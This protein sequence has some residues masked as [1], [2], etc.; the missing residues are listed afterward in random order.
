MTDPTTQEPL[1]PVPFGHALLPHFPFAPTFK[2]LNHGSFGSPPLPVLTTQSQYR[3]QLESRPDT[4]IRYT[5]GPLLDESRRAIAELV[6]APLDTVILLP[7]ATTGVNT[8]LR[9]LHYE[10]GDHIA[11]FST[12]YPACEKT[13]LYLCE[14]TAAEP[15]RVDLRYPLEDDEV[16]RKFRDALRG[17]EGRVK[18]AVLDTIV[19]LPG[20]R[21]PFEKLVQVCREEGVL[22]MIDG[23]HG[24]GHIDLD[25]GALDAD[26]FTSNCHKWLFTPRPCAILHVP[27]RNQPL[28]RSS[29]PTSHGYEPLPPTDPD[30][31]PSIANPFPPGST[32]AFAHLFSFVGTVD[33]TPYLSIPAALAFRRTVCGGEAAILSYCHGLAREGGRRAAA[34]L[35]TEVLENGTRTL[36]AGT[37]FANV[38]L[39]LSVGTGEAAD[40]G[41]RREDVAAVPAWLMRTMADES[42]VFVSVTRHAGHWWGRFSAQVYLEV[43][44]FEEGARVLK[45]LCERVG[46][47]E[48][49]RQTKGG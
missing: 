28:I 22:S 16:V 20:V 36:Q 24:L 26:F 30:S 4:F 44:D 41:V 3:T 40:G 10:R 2:N 23:A 15:V 37:C 7:N 14:S 47:G 19:S 34:V 33:P 25:L 39:P 42:D 49:V 5:Y 21:M 35:G 12:T 1:Q 27:T 13:V 45:G 46:R 29:L 11:Y 8:V 43:E 31:V 38:R 48:A 32:P 9:S 6:R 17:V 18:V